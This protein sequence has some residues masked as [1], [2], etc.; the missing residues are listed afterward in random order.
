[1]CVVCARPEKAI[2][3]KARVEKKYYFPADSS[4]LDVIPRARKTIGMRNSYAVPRDSHDAI[5]YVFY[6]RGPSS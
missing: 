1:M 2:G 6:T 3:E 5:P 4:S